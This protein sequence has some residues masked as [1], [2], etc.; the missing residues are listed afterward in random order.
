MKLVKIYN[1]Q[2]Q[3]LPQ[4]LSRNCIIKKM[5]LKQKRFAK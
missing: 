3:K 4:K 1:A 2:K 5:K